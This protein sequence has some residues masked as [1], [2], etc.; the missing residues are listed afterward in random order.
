MKKICRPLVVL[1]VLSMLFSG[2]TGCAAQ[3]KLELLNAFEKTAEIRSYE[4][5]SSFE[6][7]NITI[8]S[9]MDEAAI[10]E[11]FVA[12]LNG[13]KMDMHQKVSQNSEQ[14]IAKSQMDMAITMEGTTENSTVW[15]DSDYTQT[16]PRVRS[17]IK[18]PAST[19]GMIPGVDANIEYLVMDESLVQDAGGLDLNSYTQSLEAAKNLQTQILNLVKK[20]AID[21]DPN[22]V[23]VTQLPD[24]TI[25]GER[26]SVYQLKLT[27]ASLKALLKY[28][29][30]EIPQDENT[31]EMLKEFILTVLT[32]TENTEAGMDL[33]DTFEKFRDGTTAFGQDLNTT[34]AA[35]DDITMLGEKG[36]VVDYVINSQGYIVSQNGVIDLYMNTQQVDDALERLSPTGNYP[37]SNQSEYL[38]TAITFG[39]KFNS[40]LKRINEN[41]AIEFPVLTPENSVNFKDMTTLGA[42]SAKALRQPTNSSKAPTAPKSI[43]V[44]NS[45]LKY[46]LKPIVI[47]KHVILPLEQVCKTLGVQYKKVAKDSYS[48]TFGKR[49]VN[50]TSNS[51]EITINKAPATLS[52]PIMKI[53]NRL[54]VPECFVERYLDASVV[55]SERGNTAALIR[56]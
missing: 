23:V 25:D 24:R 37:A 6:F 56:K 20:Y 35:F 14:T 54:F 7:Q 43:E 49:T 47:G 46:D 31:K 21:Q 48:L 34:I 38:M 32:M 52:L 18:V 51:N 16:P 2:L 12:M 29:S 36:V 40:E 1:L 28:I 26:H 9:T 33:R 45:T 30:A 55:Q 10:A 50:F 19:A 5:H 39:L 22:F 27:D 41:I 42:A 11:P 8:N 53:E 13:L 17:I 4:S 3:D 44:S 15:T